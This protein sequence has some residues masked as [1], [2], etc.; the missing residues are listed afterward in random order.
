MQSNHF[1]QTERHGKACRSKLNKELEDFGLCV[2]YINS[3]IDRDFPINMNDE[4]SYKLSSGYGNN[5]KGSYTSISAS[6]QLS[7]LRSR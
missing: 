7:R 5:V 6:T 1:K 3:I 2:E 4:I